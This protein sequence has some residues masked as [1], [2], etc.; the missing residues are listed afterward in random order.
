MSDRI[1]GSVPQWPRT[2]FLDAKQSRTRKECTFRGSN[3]CS[4]FDNLEAAL[5]LQRVAVGELDPSL[6]TFH[7]INQCHESYED[8]EL[9]TVSMC[10][11]CEAAPDGY[12]YGAAVYNGGQNPISFGQGLRKRV[13]QLGGWN[14]RK[15][16]YL[17]GVNR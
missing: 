7:V 12:R 5:P 4:S 14:R 6:Q 2:G 11:I 8:F 1:N 16:T 15:D 17:G 9:S 13:I 3:A 10:R